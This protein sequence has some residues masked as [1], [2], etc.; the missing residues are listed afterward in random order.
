MAVD[1]S[2]PLDP[3]V[4]TNLYQSGPEWRFWSFDV[5]AG[6]AQPIEGVDVELGSSAQFAVL[7]GRTFVFL[8]NDDSGRTKI[9]E[10]DAAG[11]ATEH[12]DVPGD[13]FKWIRVR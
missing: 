10:I 11:V 6:T 4:V 12:L 7:D 13:V 1:F 5:N 3:E 8:P 2:Q 9:Y